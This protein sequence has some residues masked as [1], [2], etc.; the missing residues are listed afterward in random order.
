MPRP[1]VDEELLRVLLNFEA[2]DSDLERAEWERR[3]F[4]RTF[5][6]VCK[7]WYRVVTPLLWNDVD[8]AFAGTRA[9]CRGG[10]NGV[11][12]HIKMLKAANGCFEVKEVA[13]VLRCVPNL[14]QVEIANLNNRSDE[15]L[16]QAQCAKDLTHLRMLVLKR[17]G[18]FDFPRLPSLVELSL[19]DLA[20]DLSDLQT[21]L[22]P[23]V[24]P[25]L[26]ALLLRQIEQPVDAY[27]SSDEIPERLIQHIQLSSLERLDMIQYEDSNGWCELDTEIFDS[28]PLV[29]VSLSHYSSVPCTR[30]ENDSDE[31]DPDDLI[32]FDP[33]CHAPPPPRYTGPIPSHLEKRFCFPGSSP[34]GLPI[35]RSV[36]SLTSTISKPS[37]AHV[38][39]LWLPK[40][41]EQPQT[42][43]EPDDQAA[44]E[45]LYRACAR[46]EVHVGFCSRDDDD[47]DL[48]LSH[49]FWQWVRERKAASEADDEE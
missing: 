12:R 33:R 30:A 48:K 23:S 2:D 14:V 19:L 3:E 15:E 16:L 6:R 32:D 27:A 1:L 42:L 5:G 10:P 34:F 13:K 45:A 22:S 36:S 49:E 39:S 24:T 25:N 46:A 40:W 20:M 44:F 47:D 35:A 38:Q 28:G 37:S 7:Q 4:Y 17:L 21:L 18:V 41:A 26:R 11:G 9:I 29:L 31:L 8:L 43:P